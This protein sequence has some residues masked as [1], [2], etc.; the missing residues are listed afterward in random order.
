M[1][2]D[3][4]FSSGICRNL[5]IVTDICRGRAKILVRKFRPIFAAFIAL[6][7]YTVTDILVWQ[8]VFETNQMWEYAETYHVG[9]FVSLAGYGTIGIIAMWGEW[10]DCLFFLTSLFVGAFSGLEDVLYYL[11]DSKPM[12]EALP[13]LAGNPMIRANSRAGVIESVVFWLAVL[14]VLYIVLYTWKTGGQ[15]N[16]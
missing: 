16:Q 2:A 8:R 1:I 4:F 3:Q 11:L 10:K 9:W 13:W 15:R 14:I 6:L 12:P 7:F 5:V